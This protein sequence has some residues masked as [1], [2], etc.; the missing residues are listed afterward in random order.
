VRETE[1]RKLV[2]VPVST[3]PKLEGCWSVNLTDNGIGL[4]ARPSEAPLE[5]EPIEIAFALPSGSQIFSRGVVRWRHESEAATSF[6][7]RFEAFDGDSQVELLKFLAQYRV[8]VVAS[9]AP[10]GL[11][12]AFDEELHFETVSDGAG[13]EAALLRGNVSAVLACGPTALEHVRQADQVAR[14]ATDELGRPSDIRPRVIFAGQAS[15]EQLVELFN[16]GAVDQTLPPESDVPALA[17]AVRQAVRLHAMRLQEQRMAV[18]LERVLRDRR[19]PAASP[20]REGFAS[21]AMAEVLAQV[22]HL[23]GFKVTVLLQ[24]ETGTG[25]EVL[26]RK[27][28][29]L[30]P[31]ASQPFVVQ[32]CGAL[33][34]TL[35]DSELFG[36]V[37]GAFTGAVGDHPG[38][39]V[40]ADG[41]TIFLDE[42]ENTTP[43]LQ[44]KLLRVLE[45]G[46]VRPVGGSAVRRVD[47]RVIA[48]SNTVLERH[49]G[50][51]TDLYY[52]LSA[53]L[54]EVPPLRERA[55]DVL[56]LARVFIDAANL[57]HG[58]SAQGFDDEAQGALLRWHWPGNVRELR[59]AVERAVLFSGPMETMGLKRLPRALHAGGGS[60]RTLKAELERVERALMKQALERHG[61][62]LRRA[63]KELEL[64]AQTFAR[65][66][67]KLGVL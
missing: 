45:T 21:P 14:R 16:A 58:K 28:H 9:G 38:L 40:L 51:R 48:A 46:E 8:R 22:R 56:T 18:E 4:V 55:D 15:A 59:N 67:R 20:E 31:R 50:F 61:G 7:V 30:S 13:L 25:K 32:D 12:R 11:S 37:K 2:F 64:D 26:A 6:G 54:V 17:A 47:V 65:R 53:F 62:V 39:F 23:A 43:A 44:A 42:I 29:H 33:V 36:H 19:R 35:L 1:L 24:G 3:Q 27:L 34:E 66:A 41:G 52:R 49:E 60:P 5:G 57:A 10:R 63:A